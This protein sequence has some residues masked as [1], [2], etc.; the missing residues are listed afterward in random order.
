MI[1]PGQWHFGPEQITVKT[2]LGSCVA[3]TLW[4]P[5]RRI[6]GMCHYLLPDRKREP[7]Q[8]L[9]GRFASAPRPSSCW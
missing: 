2:L 1:M 3:L 9:Q 7:G 5:Q 4:H 6:G 8:P